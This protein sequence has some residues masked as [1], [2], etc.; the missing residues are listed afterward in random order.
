MMLYTVV[1]FEWVNFEKCIAKM[2]LKT[3]LS[4]F[5]L[6]SVDDVFDSD[7]KLKSQS[8]EKI[9]ISTFDICTVGDVIELIKDGA[10]AK[11]AEPQNTFI[12]MSCL[13]GEWWVR[14]YE[15]LQ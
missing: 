5:E 3:Y 9:T 15:E 13:W 1:Y 6:S 2:I 12:D 7:D 11:P 4:D 14:W 8:E 10:W